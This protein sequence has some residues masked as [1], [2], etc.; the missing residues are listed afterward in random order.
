[1]HSGSAHK[2][3][4]VLEG[5]EGD[6]TFVG[7]N[8]RRQLSSIEMLKGGWARRESVGEMVLAKLRVMGLVSTGES[9]IIIGWSKEP[10]VW[11]VEVI[12]VSPDVEGA[13]LVGVRK[14]RTGLG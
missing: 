8:G 11:I 6:G 14:R 4:D 2:D 3:E 7:G 13:V 9:S 5:L 10:F 1:M 12:E